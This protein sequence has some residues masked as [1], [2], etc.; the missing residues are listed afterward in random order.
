M[1]NKWRVFFQSISCCAILCCQ[2]LVTEQGYAASAPGPDGYGYLTSTTTYDWVDISATGTP[3]SLYDDDNSGPLNTGFSFSFYGVD[4]TQF[5]INSNGNLSFG[6]ALYDDWY[7]SS[8]TLPNQNEYINYIAMM[9]DDLDPNSGGNIYYQSYTAG[10]CP[11]TSY[12]GECLVVQFDDIPLCCDSGNPASTFEAILFDDD[13]LV[14]QYNSSELAAGW[15]SDSM[16]GIQGNNYGADHGLSYGCNTASS[17][18]AGLA[19]QF[20]TTIK[21]MD[22]SPINNVILNC[23]GKQNTLDYR[24]SRF[25]TG[26][27]DT[28]SMTYSV[29]SNNGAISGPATVPVADNSTEVFQVSLT[30]AGQLGDVVTATVT[31]TGAG[32]TLVADINM[33]ITDYTFESI[34][35][36]PSPRDEHV[37]A[38]HDGK[39]WSIAGENDQSPGDPLVQAYDP[40]T[41]SWQTI[42]GSAGPFGE[43]DFHSG[44]QAGDTVYMWDN[45]SGGLYSYN[46]ATNVWADL[47]G[48]TGHPNANNWE[49]RDAA[50]VYDPDA[51]LC[52]A[53]GGYDD[54]NSE[55]ATTVFVYQPSNNS[56]VT[57]LPEFTSGRSEHAAWIVGRGAGRKLCIAAG[58]VECG[59]LPDLACEAL[60]ISTQCLPIGASAWNAE[61]ADLGTLPEAVEE[62]GYARRTSCAGS[63]ELW[64]VGGDTASASQVASTWYYDVKNG[65]WRTGPPLAGGAA[66]WTEAVVLGN[67]LYQFGGDNNSADSSAKGNKLV[68]CK[69]CFPW[70]MFLPAITNQKGNP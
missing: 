8:C 38:A 56:W 3:V 52:Y 66:S 16:I 40:T 17:L 35:D 59:V 13:T 26:S 57:P 1:N 14:L 44:C 12:S 51:K 18:Y 70:P 37:A 27:N 46:M 50:W 49:L 29:P 42:A 48:T 6:A 62:M 28:F 19:V 32:K 69:G 54:V 55:E 23:S 7:D 43:Q 5:Y 60:K 9:S 41:D 39:I 10:S 30:P 67:E 65:V 15:G 21:V 58:D 4:Y 2:M 53:T 63:D 68:P 24:L 47:R 61:N 11:Y 20:G 22:L 33:T 34:S 31:A 36:A 25:N 45:N 64:L